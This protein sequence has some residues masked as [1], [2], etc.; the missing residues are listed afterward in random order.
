MKKISMGIDLKK[1]KSQEKT[2]LSVRSLT[3]PHEEYI[4]NYM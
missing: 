1:F 4:H 3:C 2:P